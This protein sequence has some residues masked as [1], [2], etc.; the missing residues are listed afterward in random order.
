MSWV[1]LYLLTIALLSLE[2]EGPASVEFRDQMIAL[3]MINSVLLPAARE[4]GFQLG[5]FLRGL[6]ST[7]PL[8]V[9]TDEFGHDYALRWISH[10][11]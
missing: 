3:G 1:A 2:L 8:E 7:L 4:L 10:F 9:A 6:D 11:V 5:G